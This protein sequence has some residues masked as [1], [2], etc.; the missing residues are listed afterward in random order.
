MEVG[1]NG[2]QGS[3]YY[4]VIKGFTRKKAYDILKKSLHFMIHVLL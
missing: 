1:V 3:V 4:L 2:P